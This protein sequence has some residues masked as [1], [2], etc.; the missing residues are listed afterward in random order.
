[1]IDDSDKEVISV[2]AIRRGNTVK[3]PVCVIFEF[4]DAVSFLREFVV[5]T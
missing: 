3:M 4:L 1:M 5:E 2:V